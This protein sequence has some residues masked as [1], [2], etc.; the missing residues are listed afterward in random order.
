[1]SEMKLF[2][3]LAVL[4][5][6]AAAGTE[7]T[8]QKGDD[9]A[10]LTPELKCDNTQN[11]ANGKNVCKRPDYLDNR[12][13]TYK[14]Y[15]CGPCTA[16]EKT[17]GCVQCENSAAPTACNTKNPTSMHAYMCKTMKLDGTNWIA[18]DDKQ[19]TGTLGKD[20]AEDKTVEDCFMAKEDWKK[21]ADVADELYKKLMAGGCG[22]CTALNA[23]LQPG[24][25]DYKAGSSAATMSFMLAPLLAVLFWLH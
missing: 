10:A 24:C 23:K 9:P 25:S 22:K 16:A 21:P 19:C 15:G 4:G 5:V 12:D 2:V 3:F 1:L 14:T 11:D 13:D 18:G 17:K 6:C 7:Y 20:A 8:C